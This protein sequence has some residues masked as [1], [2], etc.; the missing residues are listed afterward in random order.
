MNLA[1]RKQQVLL[2]VVENYIATGEPIGSNTL[3]KEHFS[4]VSSATIRND[5]ASLTVDGYLTQPHTSAGRAPSNLGYRYYLDNLI[6]D[7]PLDYRVQEYI[8]DNLRYSA[9]APESILNKS[10]KLLSETTGLIAITSTPPT[11]NARVHR[12]R[13]VQTGRYTAMLVLITSTGMV[14]SKL[15]RSE[16]VINEDIL[17]VY[18]KALNNKLAGVKLVDINRPF[19]Q[20]IAASFGELSLLMPCVLLA[21]QEA[22]QVASLVNISVSGESNVLFLPNMDIFNAKNIS[23]FLKNTKKVSNLLHRNPKGTKVYIGKESE[24]TEL[25]N[26]SVIVTRYEI[27]NQ[28]AGA[29]ALLGPIRTDYAT[30]ISSLKYISEVVGD[31]LDEVV[32]N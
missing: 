16:F 20:T 6:K 4:N 12:V 8:D 5:M 26:S 21:I 3:Q 24:Y 25:D 23:M 30:A 28:T 31:L 14:E 17:K 27:L 10:A 11:D 2:A 18:D 19:I 29:L 9:D 15:F 7:K 13:F 22:A 32:E 1:N